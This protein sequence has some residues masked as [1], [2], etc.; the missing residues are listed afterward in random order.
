MPIYN[1]FAEVEDIIFRGIVRASRAINII[2][3]FENVV[4]N[5]KIENNYNK[6]QL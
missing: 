4:N 3:Y 1:K 2:I 6:R 5:F